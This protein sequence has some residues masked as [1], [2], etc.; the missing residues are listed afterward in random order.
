MLVQGRDWTVY[1]EYIEE[2][3][4]AHTDDINK[5][6]ILKEALEDALAH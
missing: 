6:P 3:K 5:R 4:S 2:G 1:R